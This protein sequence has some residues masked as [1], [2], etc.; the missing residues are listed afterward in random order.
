MRSSRRGTSPRH[1]HP[2]MLGSR[3]RRGGA[4]NPDRFG[5]P[6][7]RPRRRRREGGGRGSASTRE[8]RRRRRG[9]LGLRRRVPH[10][11]GVSYGGRVGVAPF[12]RG[13]DPPALERWSSAVARAVPHL[14]ARDARRRR[15]AMA[16]AD[17]QARVGYHRRRVVRRRVAEVCSQFQAEKGLAA[18]GVVGPGSTWA[19][20]RGDASAVT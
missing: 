8:P 1:A 6:P 20:R 4:R 7:R 16:G 18:D 14:P 17:G 10:G 2:V 12:H 13:A 3:R 15:A 11:R 19:A 9:T 5:I